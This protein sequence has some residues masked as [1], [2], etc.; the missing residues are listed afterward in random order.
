MGFVHID[1]NQ[2]FCL[3]N[4][5]PFYISGINYVADYICTNFFEDWR[6]EIIQAD[7]KKIAELGLNAVRI[8]IYWGFF[9]PEEGEFNETAFERLDCFFDMCREYGLFV[10]PWC[11]VGVATKHADIPYRQGRPF[12]TGHMLFA[13]ANH[14]RYF[15]ERYRNE[16]QILCWDICDEPEFYSWRLNAEKW[17]YNTEDFEHW[18]KHMYRA[19]KDADPNHLVT[20][21]WGAVVSAN[22]GYH[23]QSGAPLDTLAVTTYP[24]D[25]AVEGMDTMRCNYYLSYYI[26]THK[27]EG[28]PVFACEAPGYSTVMFSEAMLGRYFSASIYSAM[29]EGSRG[30]LPW[31]FKDFREDILDQGQLDA[32]PKESSF[33][34]LD[35][36]NRLKATGQVLKDFAAF[37]NQENI[38]TLDCKKA[39]VVVT[40]PETYYTNVSTDKKRMWVAHQALRGCGVDMD[41]RWDTKD[42][43]DYQMA[44]VP[45]VTARTSTWKRLASF[46]ENGGSLAYFYEG[47]IHNIAYNFNSLFGVEVQTRKRNYG[48]KRIIF[49]ENLGKWKK[50]EYAILSNVERAE[51]LYVEPTTAVVV[52]RFENGDPALL[53]HQYGKGK[54]FLSVLP[55]FDGLMDISYEQ[56]V[57]DM[58]FDLTEAL[59]DWAGIEA[60]VRP[61]NHQ[62]ETGILE[63]D[64]KDALL[65]AVNHAPYSLECNVKIFNGKKKTLLPC[66]GGEHA[67]YQEGVLHLSMKAGEAQVFHIGP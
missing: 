54:A 27:Q 55:L 33:G 10:M 57:N 40:M 14:L 66:K 17:P 3:P 38:A 2:H 24:L 56:Y 34:I 60:A 20:L 30:V 67:Q 36:H 19:L 6:P 23:I 44:L 26:L 39:D 4:G 8:P 48:F 61:D 21:G 41:F 64:G 12:F 52:A 37:A 5:T 28:K 16:E 65:V 53:R 32:K 59:T 9:E 62:V 51:Y 1:Q 29:L 31:N 47:T 63:R 45:S 25:T 35:T 42:L 43:S 50:G 58:I 7:L 49:E 15:A 13:A 11:L 22:Y 18:V 46:T